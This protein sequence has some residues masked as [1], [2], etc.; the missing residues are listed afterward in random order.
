MYHI[1]FHEFN[2][3]TLEDILKEWRDHLRKERQKYHRADE[4]LYDEPV[5]EQ[6]N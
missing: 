3:N 4:E 2:G 5:E 6:M 1:P